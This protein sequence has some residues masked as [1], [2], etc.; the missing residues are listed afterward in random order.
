MRCR[1]RRVSISG[2]GA[3]RLG[4]ALELEVEAR[5]LVCLL[6]GFWYA[7]VRTLVSVW[8]ACGQLPLR[9]LNWRNGIKYRTRSG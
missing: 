5:H 7:W 9:R 4:K 6:G 2:A 8:D 1:D 3:S